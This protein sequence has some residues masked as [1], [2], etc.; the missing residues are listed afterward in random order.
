MF[1][2]HKSLLIASHVCEDW[3]HRYPLERPKS[4]RPTDLP[5]WTPLSTTERSAT[6]QTWSHAATKRQPGPTSPTPTQRYVTKEKLSPPAG[7]LYCQDCP[8]VHVSRMSEVLFPTGCC[9]SGCQGP[10]GSP[11]PSSAS[12][13]SCSSSARQIATLTTCVLS[14]RLRPAFTG[15]GPHRWHR[16]PPG[17]ATPRRASS[18]PAPHPASDQRRWPPQAAPDSSCGCP[19]LR[20]ALS[21]GLQ[22]R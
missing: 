1:Q 19:Q 8:S 11:H 18:G 9:G 15:Q 3:M 16:R 10:W 14:Q 5:P 2:G 13:Q 6:K 21:G 4:W 12:L 20:G 22:R 7:C 17:G